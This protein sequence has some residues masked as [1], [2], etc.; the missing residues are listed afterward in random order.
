MPSGRCTHCD[1]L[2]QTQE[3]YRIMGRIKKKSGKGQP[4][5][6]TASLPDIVFMLLFFFMA[7][8]V[9]KTT[10]PLVEYTKPTGDAIYRFEDVSVLA[11]I[12][13]GQEIGSPSTA[14]KVQLNDDIKSVQDITQFI[15]DKRSGLEKIGKS[16]DDLVAFM[17]IDIKTKM[18]IVNKIKEELQAVEQYEVAYSANEPK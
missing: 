1:Y 18:A 6:S 9:M 11:N 7:A 14:P 13:V 4:G 12:K 5:I 15:W 8:A 3:T 16:T 10:D 17:D 2:N